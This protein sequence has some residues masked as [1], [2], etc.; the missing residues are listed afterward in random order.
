[1]SDAQQTAGSE[2]VFYGAVKELFADA[3][4][5][6][7]RALCFLEKSVALAPERCAILQQAQAEKP[8][9]FDVLRDFAAIANAIPQASGRWSEAGPSL[10]V[11]Y[12][13]WLA[14]AQ[15][16]ASGLRAEEERELSQALEMVR[17]WEPAYRAA[18]ANY[19]AA[20]HALESAHRSQ[21]DFKALLPLQN[22]LRVSMTDW[23]AKA[24][25]AAF[26]TARAKI[27]SAANRAYASILAHLRAQYEASLKAHVTSDGTHFVPVRLGLSGSLADAAWTRHEHTL[28]RAGYP[29]SALPKVALWLK[30]AGVHTERALLEASSLRFSMELLRV[31]LDRSPWFDALLLKSRSWW[32]K[33]ATR[34]HPESG[35]PLFSD[36]TP[37]PNTGG[38]WPLTPIELILARNC[39][40]EI[41][42]SENALAQFVERARHAEQAGIENYTLR[43][44]VLGPFSEPFEFEFEPSSRLG[45]PTLQLMGCV[46]EVM[47]KMPDPDPALLPE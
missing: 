25:K 23:Q 6:P 20:K 13:D 15:V 36:G 39:N 1:M 8:R 31:P 28:S 21:R 46:A 16:P 34:T 37:P 2:S 27:T 44:S 7:H 18:E 17:H 43:S 45:A 22:Q 11:L 42:S 29:A 5:G 14:R 10:A 3:S 9:E 40:I 33:G 26:E 35:G 38:P 19:Q 32:W 47:P 24:R 30:N 4:S 12:Q 41:N